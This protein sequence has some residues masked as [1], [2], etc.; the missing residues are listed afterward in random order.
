[1]RKILIVDSKFQWTVVIFTVVISFL[2]TIFDSTL[3]R[4]SSVDAE[5]VSAG[6]GHSWLSSTWLQVI[7]YIAF[8]ASVVFLSVL[9]SNRLAGPIYR[10]GKH[11]LNAS[12]GTKTDHIFLRDKDYYVDLTT[13][14]NRL[15]DSLPEDRRP[16]P[17][18]QKGF[19]LMEIMVVVVIVSILAT[20]GTAT[21][22]GGTTGLYRFKQETMHLQELLQTAR[23]IAFGRSQCVAVEIVNAQEVKTS[24]YAMSNPCTGAR[25]VPV[26]EITTTFNT[27][28]TVANFSIGNELMFKPT[29]GI[30]SSQPVTIKIS[31]TNGTSSQLIIYPAIGQIRKM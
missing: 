22:M 28:T 23:N 21:L 24:A 16:S 8:Y 18:N 17:K 14:Y 11:M 15:L 7:L 26:E 27:S 20:L 9:F 10:L 19:T 4:L 12:Q 5:R 3:S 30:G 13:S 31:T 29:G 2:T 25:P 1:M 6:L